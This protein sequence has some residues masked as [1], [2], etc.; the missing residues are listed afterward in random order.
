MRKA[1][2]KF[3]V[4]GD[5]FDNFALV[6]IE[7]LIDKNCFD[8]LESPIS[9]GKEANVFSAKRGSD[10]VAVKI[11]RLETC[12]FNR[13]YDYIRADPRYIGMKKK[14][15]QVILAWCQREYRNL[16]KAR[17]A[18]LSAPYP[19]A[20]LNNILVSEYIGD[21]NPAPKLK[22]EIPKELS[23]FAIEVFTQVR[24]FYKAGYVHSDLSEFN[25]LIFNE[26]PVFIDFSQ[27][28]TDRNPNFSEY[29]KR[30]IKN[31]CHFFRKKGL[32]LDEDKIAAYIKGDKEKLII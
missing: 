16:M 2:E 13:M 8:E 30:D 21:E 7:K 9:V 18:G 29:L 14:R 20:F 24:K 4:W 25:I 6:T 17:E 28:T 26:K 3:K 11:Y 23:A 10:R 12:D 19:I 27:A 15:R 5:V 31:M 22:D 32:S 1:N